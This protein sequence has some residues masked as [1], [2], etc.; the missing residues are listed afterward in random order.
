MELFV[1]VPL[2]I[3]DDL[4]THYPGFHCLDSRATI[5]TEPDSALATVSD[6]T[7]GG[8]SR[9]PF[10]VTPA[11]E[12]PREKVALWKIRISNLAKAFP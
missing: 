8:T 2:L 1:S 10:P 9:P 3:I 12:K 5:G 11:N 4:G 7:R 6:A